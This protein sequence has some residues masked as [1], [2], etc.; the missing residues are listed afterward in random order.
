MEQ[1]PDHSSPPDDKNQPNLCHECKINPSKYKCPGCSLRSCS[2]PCVN[3]HKKRTAC[4]GKRPLTNFVPVSQFDDNLLISDYNMLEDVKRIA[5]SAQRMRIKLC[6]YSNF[7]VPYPLKS[8]R[9]AAASRRTKLLFH[10]RGMSKRQKNQSYYDNKMKFIAWTIEW[11]FHSTDVVLVDH[12]V[13]ENSTLASVIENHLKPGPWNHSLRQFCDQNLDSLNFFT[14]KYPKGP[15]SPFLRLNIRAPIRE[16]LANMIILEY[17]VIHVYLPS[18]TYDFHVL[19]DVPPR[20][21]EINEPT[22]NDSNPITEGVTF[23]EEE[24]EDGEFLDPLV[25]DL[26][27]R[28]TERA[29]PVTKRARSVPDAIDGD[30][31][32]ETKSC[33]EQ[34][35]EIGDLDFDFDFEP[36]I[37]DVYPEQLDAN[38]DELFDFERELAEERDVE[39]GECL[40]EEELEEGE[41]A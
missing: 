41:I 40:A 2:L 22:N 26:M 38:S 29:P 12:G 4:T 19:N 6:G 11:R 5:D 28:E 3:S 10:S 17:P 37:N 31:S 36:D 13:N 34:L 21:P 15:K 24:I 9:S 20:K 1:K 39:V 8:L 25:S 16:Q 14:R 30:N 7:R 18:H 23:K 32:I 27:N 35:D 33:I